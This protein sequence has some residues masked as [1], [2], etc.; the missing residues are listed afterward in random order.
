VAKD[1]RLS[2]AAR[3]TQARAYEQ[4]AVALL[5]EAIRKGYRDREHL[6]TEGQ[7]AALRTLAGFTESMKELSELVE[8]QPPRAHAA[9]AKLPN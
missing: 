4:R 3:A 9:A 7:L 1:E 5:N 6:K 2:Q 8:S